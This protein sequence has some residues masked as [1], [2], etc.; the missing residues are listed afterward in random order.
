L[1][2]LP[3]YSAEIFVN[4]E[5]VSALYSKENANVLI[6]FVTGES[7]Q[8]EYVIELKQWL[9]SSAEVRFVVAED[10]PLYGGDQFTE[11]ISV[12]TL[13]YDYPFQEHVYIPNVGVPKTDCN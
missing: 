4:G 13:G 9:W 1:G 12:E 5:Q 8:G 2:W 10:A 6:Y 3:G 11:F 7:A